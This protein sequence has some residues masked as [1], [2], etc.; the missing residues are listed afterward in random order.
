MKSL[1]PNNLQSLFIE[2]EKQGSL[3]EL[4]YKNKLAIWDICRRDI[5]MEI[6]RLLNNKPRSFSYKVTYFVVFKNFLN[7]IINQIVLFLLKHKRARVLV[8]C[9]RRFRLNELNYD[10]AVDPIASKF[11]DC[12]FLDFANSSIFKAIF[13][14]DSSFFKYKIIRRSYKDIEEFSHLID[15]YVNKYFNLDFYSK[16]IVEHALDCFFS[17]EFFFKNL[18][19][20]LNCE[21]V[22]YSENGILKCIPYICNINKINCYEVQHGAG[23]GSISKTYPKKDFLFLNKKNCYYPDYFFLWGE[24]W[25]ENYNIPSKKVVI[26][27]YHYAP[28]L[29]HSNKILFI[30]NNSYYE[31]LSKIA[32]ELNSFLPNRKI[33][34]KLHPQQFIDYQKIKKDFENQKNIKVICDMDTIELLRESSDIVAIRSSF[35]YQALQSGCQ[36]HILKK[37]NYNWDQD[38]LNYTQCFSNSEE[39]FKN[40]S[41]NITHNSL[42]VYFEKINI[43]YL[44]EFI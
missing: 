36:V 9:F 41:K 11:D 20:N 3:F 34:F 37:A 44:N 35:I 7:K 30:S 5:F 26:G 43:R 6:N 28:K 19:K 32:K 38:L 4:V 39:L 10:Y 21:K 8:I 16:E 2:M 17:G 22:I 14:R 23:P 18:I 15:K 13:F 31:Y 25:R 40:L 1:T 33:F 27:T 29:T 12:F 42:P 24:Y